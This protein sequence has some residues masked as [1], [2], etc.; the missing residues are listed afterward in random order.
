MC[1]DRGDWS[2]HPQPGLTSERPETPK[3][4]ETKSREIRGFPR[5]G[6]HI[7]THINYIHFFQTTL[8]ASIFSGFPSAQRSI[9]RAWSIPN[10]SRIFVQG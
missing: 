2:E 9:Q 10:Q 7:V 5:K 4:G 3:F 8:V 6:G 1:I